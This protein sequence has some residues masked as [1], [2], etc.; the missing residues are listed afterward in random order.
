MLPMSFGRFAFA[1]MLIFAIV[2]LPLSAYV[3][4][5]FYLGERS[6]LPP[7]M[8]MGSGI[9]IERIYPHEWQPYVFQP[10]ANV[11]QWLRGVDVVIGGPPPP[12][13]TVTEWL[14]QTP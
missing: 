4:S 2:A 10:A 8:G 5:Y 6:D 7:G 3:A 11:E 1:A 12:A 14:D 9:R 13:L